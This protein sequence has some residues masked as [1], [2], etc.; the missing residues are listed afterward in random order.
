MMQEL[1]SMIVAKNKYNL[2]V[3]PKITGHVINFGDTT[4][5]A[6]K[7]DALKLFYH[8]VMPHKGWQQYD[9]ISVKYRGQV[10]A[11]RKDKT[12][13]N[14]SEDPIEEI[15]MEEATL[16]GADETRPGS[17]PQQDSPINNQPTNREEEA[18]TESPAPSPQP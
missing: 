10:V 4:R 2:I 14:V 3:V 12:K 6:E 9:T 16:P 7:R 11:T 5:L 15:D 8:R 18:G 13:L 1:T 17:T